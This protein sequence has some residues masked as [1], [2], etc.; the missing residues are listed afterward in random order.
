MAKDCFLQA[1]HHLIRLQEYN[2][3]SLSVPLLLPHLSH[4]SVLVCKFFMIKTPFC[5]SLEHFV[6]A[7]LYCAWYTCSRHLPPCPTFVSSFSLQLSIHSL[8]AYSSSNFSSSGFE[9][10]TWEVVRQ[11][12]PMILYQRI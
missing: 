3:L 2:A 5:S 12:H 11:A 9:K 10:K 6:E 1:V 4:P 8:A 7:P